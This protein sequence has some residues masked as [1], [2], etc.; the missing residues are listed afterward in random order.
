MTLEEA[1]IFFKKYNGHGFHMSRED[2]ELHKEFRQLNISKEQQDIWRVEK[3]E[4]YH[5]LIHSEEEY[6]WVWFRNIIELMDSLKEVTDELL[7]KLLDI[8]VY[9]GKLDVSQRILVM[10]IMAGNSNDPNDNG[11]MLYKSKNKYYEKL[12]QAMAEI[13][14]MSQEDKEEMT[15]L[16]AKGEMGWTDTYNRYLNALKKCERVEESLLAGVGLENNQQN[17]KYDY[18]EKWLALDEK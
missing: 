12:Q 15:R 10:E 2:S 5:N 9:I 4:E 1:E 11:Y 18:W 6:A 3:I 13:I 8:L 17:K 16:S 7:E 14:H